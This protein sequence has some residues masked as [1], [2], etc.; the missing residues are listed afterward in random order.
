MAIKGLSHREIEVLHL[1]AHEYTSHEIGDILYIS[2]HTVN[3]HRKSLQHKLQ[4]RNT[5]GL[6][7]RAFELGLLKVKERATFRF[8]VDPQ[9][10]LRALS[11]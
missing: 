4:V 3:S 9:P 8:S 5:A 1:I 7:R 11:A 2:N 6:I 10:Y